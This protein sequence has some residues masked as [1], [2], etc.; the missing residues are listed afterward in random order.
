MVHF[1]LNRGLGDGVAAVT[2]SV[3]AMGVRARVVRLLGVP[4]PSGLELTEGPSSG[5]WP[6]VTV[7][8]G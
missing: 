5:S 6:S 3:W 4:G 2:L 1:D 7:K 8:R